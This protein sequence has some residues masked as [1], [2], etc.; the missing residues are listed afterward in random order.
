MCAV[1]LKLQVLVEFME[2]KCVGISRAGVTNARLVGQMQLPA[3]IIGL[4]Q[5]HL[6]S[7]TTS[8]EASL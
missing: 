2:T 5:R 3:V 7:S 6:F 1:L 8:A 4:S